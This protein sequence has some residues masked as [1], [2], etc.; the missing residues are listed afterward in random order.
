MPLKN[1]CVG[2]EKLGRNTF[3]NVILIINPIVINA[4]IMA[5]TA[6]TNAASPAATIA[7]Q[8]PAP[9]DLPTGKVLLPR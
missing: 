9:A 7:S 3:E 1:G 8:R 2:R 5:T 4:I 6:A